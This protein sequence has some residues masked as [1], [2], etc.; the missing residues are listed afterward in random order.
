MGSIKSN[1]KPNKWQDIIPASQKTIP[2]KIR[3]KIPFLRTFK[4]L[5]VRLKPLRL[6]RMLFSRAS[7][8]RRPFIIGGTVVLVV[9]GIVSL[10]SM[11]GIIT[12]NP[13]ADQ[14]TLE[15][16]PFTTTQ[17][18]KGTPDYT[19]MLPA[20]KSIEDFGGW[21]RVS[22][23]NKDPVFAYVDS[24]GGSSINVSQQPLPPGFRDDTA[25]QVSL[26]AQDFN[27]SQVLTVGDTLVYI[28]TSAKGPQSV[29][30]TKNELL[31]LIRSSV[32]ISNELWA[33]YVA[34][35]N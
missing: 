19:T 9:I 7:F 14:A 13:S 26:L 17:L 25:E 2:K 29:I 31:I 28:G 10:T 23:T 34:S 1:G 8:G 4:S 20:G 22:P 12:P 16:V 32:V 33:S 6:K 11:R 21:T 35:L 24:L 3:K 30:L 18:T 5:V 15:G 27:A